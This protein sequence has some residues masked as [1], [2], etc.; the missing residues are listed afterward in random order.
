MAEKIYDYLPVE[1]DVGKRGGS[2]TITIGKKIYS[3]YGIEEGDTLV[4]QILKVLKKK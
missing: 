4:V 3:K 2:L 1:W